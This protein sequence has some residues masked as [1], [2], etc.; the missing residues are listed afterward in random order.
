MPHEM[1]GKTFNERREF[2]F[3]RRVLRDFPTP[4]HCV[5]KSPLN[6]FRFCKLQNRNREGKRKEKKSSRFPPL[7][8]RC[9]A[10][11]RRRPP[12]PLSLAAVRHFRHGVTQFLEFAKFHVDA[13]GRLRCP[14]KRCLN[15]NWSSLEGVERH[16]LTIG[17]SPYYTEWVYHGESLSYRGT[18]NFE[19]GTSSNPFNEGTSSTQFNE[20]GDIF[21]MLNDLQAPIEHEEEIEEFRLEDEMAMNVG[22]NIDEDTTN[23]IFQDLLNQARNELYPGCSE[24]SSLNFLVKLMHVKVLNGW[25]NKSFDM[26]LELLRAAFPMC[27][28]T[29]PSSFYE[30]KRKLRDLGLGY[31]TIHACKYD[32]VLYWKEFADLQHCPTCGEARY[33]VNHNRGKKIPHKVLRHFPLVPRLQR[34]FVSQEGSADMRWHR[35]KRVETDDVLR[36]PADA[37]GWK[38]FDSEFP[39]FASDPRNVRLGLASDGFNPFGQMST[40]Y[41]MWPVVLLPY[42]LPPWKCMKETNFFMSLLIPGPKSPG[43]EIDVYLQPLIEELKDLWTFGVRTYDSLTGQFFQL[44]AALLWTIN[45]FPAYG[46]LSGWSTKGYQACPICM[47]DRSSFGIRGRISF[48]GHRRYLPQNHV[49]RRS[50]LHDGKVERKAPPVVMNGHEILEQLD[51]LEF[52]VMSKHPSIQDKKRKRALNWTK[53]SI[54]FNLPYW[55]RLLLR[56]K[57]DVMHIEKNVCDNLIG[58]LLNI[59]GKTKDTTNARL[60]LQDLKIRK[61]LHLVEVGNRLVKPHASYTLTTSE[62]VEFCKFLK[63]NRNREGKREEKPRGE[64]IESSS[65]F[66]VLPPSLAAVL[67]AVQPPSATLAIM[68]YRRSNFMETDDM[69]LQFEDDLDNNIAGGSSYVGD[70][71]ESS[72]QQA[73]PTPRR[74]AQS[75]LLELERHVGIN[76]RISMTIAPGA[77]KPISPHAVRFSQ[78]ICVCVRKTFSVRCLKWTDVRREFIEVVKGDLQLS[79]TPS[80]DQRVSLTARESK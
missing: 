71:T 42:N 13:Y 30:A 29:I 55:S 32:C 76:G 34:L 27:N 73:T 20:E 57:L 48:M 10:A 40:S 31:E 25:S 17:I 14:C 38:H 66:R 59:E 69:F 52:P 8:C 45:D 58:T 1:S 70:N 19:E 68:S 18:E 11:V 2:P 3:S 46:D 64:K 26:L 41:S 61:D 33:K 7:F 12:S 15:L 21:G 9:S 65:P 56:H 4:R 74:R 22:V 63:S 51:Q 67:A 80:L 37:E 23:N 5:G 53:K 44:Y 75:R 54:F 50:R 39:D 62:R 49:W 36:H 79:F 43:R 28:S 16:L 6:S 60:D 72:S 77:E 78:A 47:S 35:D 24:F